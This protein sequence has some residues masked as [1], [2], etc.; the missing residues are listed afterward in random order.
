MERS[1]DFCA[2]SGRSVGR[3]P[4]RSP[5]ISLVEFVRLAEFVRRLGGRRWTLHPEA[6]VRRL[7]AYGAQELIGIPA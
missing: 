2:E 6:T 3:V 1:T 5:L 4:D 7:T